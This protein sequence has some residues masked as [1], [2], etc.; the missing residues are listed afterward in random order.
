MRKA[1][2]VLVGIH[3]L[4]QR[5]SDPQLAQEPIQLMIE[6]VKNAAV[7]AGSPELLNAN[8]VR[9]IKGIWP[10]QNPGKAIADAIGCPGA[11]SVIS[12]FGGNFVQTTVNRSAL[13]IQNG[14]HDVIILTGAEC[15]STQAKAAKAKVD[16]DW[17][18]LP[19]Q[20]DQQFGVDKDMRHDAERAIR[21]G[22]PIAVYPIMELALRHQLGLGV[23]EHLQ[24]ISELW[25]S[26]NQVAVDNPNAWIRDAKTATEIRTP[27]A[28]N[29]PVSFPYPKFMNSNDNVDQAAALIMCS[30]AK[31]S[32]LGIPRDKWIYPWAGSDA[33]DHYYLSNRDNFY[34][35]PAIRFAGNR[36]L[37]MAGV[38]AE[39]L[40]MVDVY[41]CFPVAVQVASR[42]LNLD[43]TKPLTVTGGL[44]W[45]GGPLNN[46]V[47]HSIVRMAQL[48]REK[49]GQKGLI[50][51]NGGYIT[52][53]A[54][55]V[56]SS[57]PPSQPYQYADVQQ[58]VDNTFKR[59]VTIG[60]AGEG[61]VE[62]YSV[63][64]GASGLEKAFVATRLADERRAWGVCQDQ[65]V[66]QSM[67]KEEFCGRKVKL[68]DHV[69][70]F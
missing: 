69:A 9:V 36:C 32:S 55:G 26:F 67:T 23:A 62:G 14:I 11:E 24:R 37:E 4:E 19:G 15:G 56:Y 3:H 12:T 30:E 46:Y 61:I 63:V 44:T 33:Q 65:D 21:L 47:M 42:E 66:L 40:D 51:A 8:S 52:K 22:R 7:D 13:D 34:S 50:T 48:L 28:I 20:P 43:T 25:A 10:Y 60:H 49:Q 38:N 6:A 35:S 68:A 17:A 70:E 5:Q 31:A 1:I 53:H 41:S 59:E 29:R 27:S 18:T 2:P 45:A 58:Q 16:L 39:D 54:F 64:Y 57:E